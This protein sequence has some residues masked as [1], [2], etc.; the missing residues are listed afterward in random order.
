MFENRRFKISNQGD[1]KSSP[2]AR[3]EPRFCTVAAF[4]ELKIFC[5]DR[6]EGFRRKKLS[7]P[8]FGLYLARARARPSWTWCLRPFWQRGTR[9]SPHVRAGI[10][11]RRLKSFCLFVC[12]LVDL[13]G[14]WLV[15]KGLFKKNRSFSDLRSVIFIRKTCDFSKVI[16]I[17]FRLQSR[18]TMSLSSPIWESGKTG[19]AR[20]RE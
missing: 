1:H 20:K 8:C 18:H 9:D 5:L 10:L 7:F 15:L 17:E 16:L 11:R 12:C 19:E 4:S 3:I 13:K 6:F 14:D 2:S